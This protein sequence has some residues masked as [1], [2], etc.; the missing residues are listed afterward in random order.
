MWLEND[1][2]GARVN[3]RCGGKVGL[4]CLQ[5]LR[6]NKH[7]LLSQRSDKVAIILL[8]RETKQ[9]LGR[10]VSQ[11]SIVMQQQLIHKTCKPYLLATLP[12]K[13]DQRVSFAGEGCM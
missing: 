2:I 4:N 10:L 11:M 8:L 9:L 6:Q 12:L 3:G 1:N 7:C 13:T 5:T